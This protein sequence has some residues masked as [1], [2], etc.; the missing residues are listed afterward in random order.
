MFYKYKNNKWKLFTKL[1]I[2]KVSMATNDKF[3]N[4]EGKFSKITSNGEL[5]Q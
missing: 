2:T 4:Q 3:Q 1:T 5:H